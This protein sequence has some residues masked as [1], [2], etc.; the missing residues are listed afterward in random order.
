MGSSARDEVVEPPRDVWVRVMVVDLVHEF[1][2]G[3]GV[4]SFRD[5]NGGEGSP[6]GGN[7]SIEA[8]CY[9]FCQCGEV[10]GGAVAGFEAMLVSG[11]WDG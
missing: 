7:F 9:G 8:V 2:S 4:K 5:V 10:G 1:V 11:L 3:D 6:F